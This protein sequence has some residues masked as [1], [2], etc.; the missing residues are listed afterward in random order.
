[1]VNNN[2]KTLETIFIEAVRCKNLDKVRSCINLDVNVNIFVD[3]GAPLLF[4]ACN[5]PT[6]LELFLAQP[7]IDVNIKNSNGNTFL[8]YAC[9]K[10]RPDIVRRLCQVPGIDLNCQNIVGDAAVWVAVS[11]NQPDCVQVL[12]TV[13]GVNWNVKTN[14]DGWT[15]I[16][17]AVVQGYVDVLRILLTIPTIDFNVTDENGSSGQVPGIDLNCQTNNG[18][19]PAIMAVNGNKLDCVQVLSTVPGVNWNIKTNNGWAPITLAVVKG[20]IDILRILLTISTID[21]NVTDRNGRSLAQIAVES[22]QPTSVQCLELLSRD[23]RV[24]WNI[25][26]KDGDTPIMYTWKNRKSEMFKLLMNVLS[27]DKNIFMQETFNV[28]GGMSAPECP[29]CYERFTRNSQVFQC[30]LGHFVCE[31]CHSRVTNCSE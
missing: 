18:G 23:S 16:T 20:Y 29:V 12:S 17:W 27:I 13:P 3:D 2:N 11:A 8:M 22:G 10:G 30:T 14:S 1:M 9:H 4:H 24:N 6:M 26:N 31:G 19:T 25:R 5:T 21:F 15:P 28:I 7:N